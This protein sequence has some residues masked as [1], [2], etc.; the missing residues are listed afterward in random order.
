LTGMERVPVCVAY[1]VDGVRHDEMPVSQSDFHHATPIYEDLPGWSQDI[2]D[3]R[4][5]EDLPERCREYVEFVEQQIGAR[6][7]VIGVGPGR[8]EV[9]VRHDLLEAR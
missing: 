5:Y 6:I 1:D 8:D 2:S 4:R 7:S 9:I 3:T